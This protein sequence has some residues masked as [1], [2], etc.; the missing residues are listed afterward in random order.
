MPVTHTNRR[1]VTYYLHVGETKTGK[2]K[3]YFSK[4]AEGQ[5]AD[6]IPDGFEIVE[7][8]ENGNVTLRKVRPTQITDNEKAALEELCEHASNVKC[9]IEIDGDSLVVHTADSGPR[10]VGSD[11]DRLAQLLGLEFTPVADFMEQNCQ[12]TKMLRFRL[13]NASTRLFD[14]HRWC[15]RSSVEDWLPLGRRGD[16]LEIAPDVLATLDSEEFYELF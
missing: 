16:L 2:P 8:I 10:D 3:W 15:F 6:E 12:Y 1:G 13:V 9:L 4:K 14:V 11:S 5:L 7:K